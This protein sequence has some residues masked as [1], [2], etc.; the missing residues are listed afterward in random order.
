MEAVEPGGLLSNL[1]VPE[2]MSNSVATAGLVPMIR[3]RG[4]ANSGR[5]DGNAVMKINQYCLELLL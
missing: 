5:F 4:Q 2:D 1:A 3:I